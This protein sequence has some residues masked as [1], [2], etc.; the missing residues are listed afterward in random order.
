MLQRL[1]G[2]FFDHDIKIGDRKKRKETKPLLAKSRAEVFKGTLAILVDS[3]SASASE[4]FA[5]VMQLEKRG[6]V[7]GDQTLG[8]VME[9]YDFG[10]P[11]N[12]RGPLWDGLNPST[13][14]GASITVADLSMSDGKSLE[15]VGVT[16]DVVILPS[17]S[18]LAERRDPVLARAAVTLGLQLDGEKAGRIFP[19][20]SETGVTKKVT[21]RPK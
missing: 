13:F 19:R 14:Y 5:R 3:D 4:I 17:G 11:L 1:L 2:Y 16:P 7:I 10:Y 8:M 18:D 9:A 21:Q 6:T 20:D 15:H 12:Y